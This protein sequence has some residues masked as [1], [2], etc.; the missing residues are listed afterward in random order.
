MRQLV[1]V[2][3]DTLSHAYELLKVSDP[4]KR[5]RLADQV[6]RGELTLV[7][8]REQIEGRPRREPVDAEG[9]VDEPISPVEARDV[10]GADDDEWMGVRSSR[11]LTDDSLIHAKQL[12]TEA[13]EDLVGVLREPDVVRSISSTDRSNLAKY[14]TIAKLKLENAIAVVRSGEAAD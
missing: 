9:E 1:S 14:L 11:P 12:L 8:L 2:R 13:L 5:R 10:E 3:K 7:K 6:A 4:K